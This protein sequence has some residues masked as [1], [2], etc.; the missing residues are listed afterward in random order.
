[1]SIGLAMDLAAVAMDLV[2]PVEIGGEAISIP[3]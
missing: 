1:M 3:T 2:S